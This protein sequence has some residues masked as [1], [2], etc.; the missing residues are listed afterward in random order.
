MTGLEMTVE[1][2]DSEQFRDNFEVE[3]ERKGEI[4]GFLVCFFPS[5]N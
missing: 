1:M 2:E 4:K 3:S 5:E